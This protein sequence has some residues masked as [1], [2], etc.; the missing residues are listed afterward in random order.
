MR[1][2]IVLLISLVLMLA[3]VLAL[4]PGVMA[5]AYTSSPVLFQDNFESGESNWTPLS[6]EVW[7]VVDDGT[8]NHVYYQSSDWD[9]SF[10]AS[11]AGNTVWTDYRLEVRMKVLEPTARNG[12]GPCY[13]VGSG[14]EWWNNYWQY[15]VQIYD[16]GRPALSV[17]KGCHFLGYN[18]QL[19]YTHMDWF[20]PNTWLKITVEVEGNHHKVSA[21]DGTN[22]A[23]FEFDDNSSP[24]TSGGIGLNASGRAQF[25]DVKVTN[26]TFVGYGFNGLLAPY[27]APP[28][29]FKAGSTIPLK[30]QYTDSAGNVV[31]SPAANPAVHIYYD[32]SEGSGSEVIPVESPGASG[33]RYDSLTMTWGYNWQ[34]KN[35]QARLYKVCITS[36]QTGQTDGP[37]QILLR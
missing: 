9:N 5:V 25:D 22:V 12:Y 18:Q 28:K 15:Q 14:E 31:D 7:E 23:A 17:W 1:K 10:A 37:F 2:K 24:L 36:S 19:A 29:A 30:W 20:Q 21:T 34:T 16:W 32:G 33:L 8:G 27:Q 35:L 13:R 4:F 26:L 6:P 11:N 3:T